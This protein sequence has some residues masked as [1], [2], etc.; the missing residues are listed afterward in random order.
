VRH[1]GHMG[2]TGDFYEEDEPLEDVLRAFHGGEKGLT[3]R[4][5][6]GRTENFAFD[7]GVVRRGWTETL[8]LPGILKLVSDLTTTASRAAAH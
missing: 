7:A 8:N 3:G 6:A 5:T 1:H 4:P 2:Q